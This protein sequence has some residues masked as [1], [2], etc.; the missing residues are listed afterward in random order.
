M[1]LL[2]LPPELLSSIFEFLGPEFFRQ[3]I[4][5]LTISKQWYAHAWRALV[6]DLRLTVRT[7]QQFAR[8]GSA[9][10]AEIR[11]HVNTVILSF[12]G[13]VPRRSHDDESADG[14]TE[15]RDAS[16][17]SDGLYTALA[18]LAA[19][20]QESPRLRHLGFKW[21]PENP[22]AFSPRVQKV[23]RVPAALNQF[24][25]LRQ[26]TSLEFD[27]ANSQS[28]L[29]GRSGGVH[30]CVSINSLLPS[31]RRLR[32]RMAC[33]CDALLKPPEDGRSLQLNELI[34]NLCVAKFKG[35]AGWFR[36]C[37]RCPFA[38]EYMDVKEDL[39]EAASKLVRSMS[40]PQMV[41]IVWHRREPYRVYAFDAI[42]RQRLRLH[43][44]TRWDAD[45]T[46]LEEDE[47]DEDLADD[48]EGSAG[49]TY[50][51][52]ESFFGSESGLGDW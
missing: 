13:D 43:D 1:S 48:S 8:N 6:K 5:L 41:R 40:N 24:F 34:V 32:C 19:Q 46:V 45:G 12:G 31:L 37:D 39:K 23:S 44:N 47:P 28:L 50:E 22:G 38:G 17:W 36:T 42:T 29:Q 18:A 2:Q 7:V 14:D 51:D 15:S 10:L 4:R 11:P 49:Y 30:Y 20:L 3:D 9:S 27:M 16:V 33:V 25:T 26:L 21:E 52:N 35:P